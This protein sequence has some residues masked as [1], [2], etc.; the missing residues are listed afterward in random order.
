MNATMNRQKIETVFER[1]VELFL[2]ALFVSVTFSKALMEISFALTLVTWLSLKIIRREWKVKLGWEGALL[3]GFL[4]FTSLS[5]ANSDYFYESFRGFIKV[6]KNILTFIIVADTFRTEESIKRLFKIMVLALFASL[7][8]GIYQFIVTKDLIRGFPVSYTNVNRRI[9]SSFGFPGLFGAFLITMAPLLLS[10]IWYRIGTAKERLFLALTSVI[11]FLS[12]YHTHARGA[13]LGGIL[14]LIVLSVFLGKKKMLAAVIVAI[15]AGAIFLPKSAIV[16]LD[17]HGKEQSIVERFVLWERAIDCIKAKPFF[18]IG[19]N[20]YSKSHQKYDTKKSWR[21]KG[22][23]A[24]NGYLQLA[25]ETG[26]LS[27]GCFLGFLVLFFINNLKAILRSKV[28]LR[29]AGLVGISSGLIA[30]LSFAFVDTL[31][32]SLPMAFL[33]WFMLGLGKSLRNWDV[34]TTE[35]KNNASNNDLNVFETVGIR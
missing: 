6:A 20:T 24:H 5:I 30:Y 28:K 25:A 22:Y 10:F 29:K 13:W 26:L 1:A 32:H 17:K 27:L 9:N 14:S 33:L 21:V 8:N 12:L 7:L 11:L 31:M 18:G 3:G 23:Y 34:A 4:L 19:I 2:M 35:T 15:V 16:H